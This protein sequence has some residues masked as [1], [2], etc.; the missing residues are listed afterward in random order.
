MMLVVCTEPRKSLC[1]WL[2]D[3]SSWPCL[4]FLPGPAWLQLSK[5]C[6]PFFSPLYC[7]AQV[8]SSE[9]RL[10]RGLVKFVPAL[11]CLFCLALLGTCLVESA[12]LISEPC[13]IITF[14]TY[15]QGHENPCCPQICTADN[16]FLVWH[17]DKCHPNEGTLLNSNKR[18]EFAAVQYTKGPLTD[19]ANSP[20]AWYSSDDDDIGA[21]YRFVNTIVRTLYFPPTPRR[22]KVHFSMRKHIQCKITHATF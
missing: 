8:Q 9:K 20:I 13:R 2:R 6:K 21:Q 7:W 17:S 4:A 5:I 11:A 22:E 3:I 14:S 12:Y 1:T 18:R 10:V 16:G 15:L 19:A